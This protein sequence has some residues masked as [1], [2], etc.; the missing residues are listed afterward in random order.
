MAIS[1]T[2]G[3]AGLIRVGATRLGKNGEEEI[4]AFSGAGRVTLAMR[5]VKIPVGLNKNGEAYDVHR[6]IEELR[7]EMLEAAEA[8]EFERAAALR[9]EMLELQ[10]AE[11]ERK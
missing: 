5:G 11:G 10:E 7:K 4:A 9:D 1:T 8:L 2:D 3:V 6:A